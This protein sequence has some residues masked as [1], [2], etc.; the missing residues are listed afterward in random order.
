MSLSHG[1]VSSP[2][3]RRRNV[4]AARRQ[5]QT[6]F[7]NRRLLSALEHLEPRVVLAV[8]LVAGGYLDP[9][10][11]DAAT[12]ELSGQFTLSDPAD[13]VAI[14]WSIYKDYTWAQNPDGSYIKDENDQYILVSQEPN[15]VFDVDIADGTIIEDALV[16]VAP[17]TETHTEFGDY[18]VTASIPNSITNEDPHFAVLSVVDVADASR[19]WYSSL[20]FHQVQTEFSVT[21][22]PITASA[23]EGSSVTLTATSQS[24]ETLYEWKAFKLVDGIPELEPT[25]TFT[26]IQPNFPF[27]PP[28]DGLYLIQLQATDYFTGATAADFTFLTVGDVA[29]TITASGPTEAIPGF[30]ISYSATTTQ[31]SVDTITTSWKIVNG[32]NQI[33]ASGSGTAV[34]Y[35]PTTTGNY[36]V[37]FTVV[38]DDNSSATQTIALSVSNSIVIGGQLLIG[39]SA[40]GSNIGL[41]AGVGGL[42]VTVNGVTTPLGAGITAINIF[43]QGGNDTFLITGN[44][45]VPITID[46]GAGN[47]NI[48]IGPGVTSNVLALGGAGNDIIIGGS[49]NNIL[50]GGDGNDALTGGVQ[51]DLLIG[52]DGVDI[53]LGNSQDDILIA[54]STDYDNSPQTLHDILALWLLNT[55]FTSRVNSLSGLL[56]HSTVHDDGDIDILMGLGGNDWFLANRVGGSLFT[57]DLLLDASGA[58]ISKILEL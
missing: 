17:T 48:L 56:N 54:G 47:D 3:P 14:T 18:T 1:L 44:I 10:V 23:W 34:T 26:S 37:E 29:P 45:S 55:S 38:D 32:S 15:G 9:V 22:D 33:V 20:E 39:A 24:A 21:I 52:G 36:S 53:L 4:A 58:E 11:V 2:R 35:T 27:V 43:G 8:D 41:S 6:H 12:I 42:S 49:G 7:K 50:V 31:A 57:R 5:Q 25:F 19:T 30:P 51:R 13:N 28:D 40:G 16:S 46:A